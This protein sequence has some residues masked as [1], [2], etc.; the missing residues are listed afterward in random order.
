MP[1]YRKSNPRQ[2]P[3][4]ILMWEPQIPPMWACL[5]SLTDKTVLH[6]VDHASRNDSW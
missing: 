3:S 4:P 2:E 1:V 6:F 5:I